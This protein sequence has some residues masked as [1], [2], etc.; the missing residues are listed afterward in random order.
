ML[1][2]PPNQ[3]RQSTE[4][5]FPFA[6]ARCVCYQQID[7]HRQLLV[8][9]TDICVQHSG[10]DTESFTAAEMFVLFCICHCFCD[11]EN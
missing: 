8:Y 1:F 5:T 9:H 6:T 2:L 4:A 11:H 10:H 3:Q 7:V